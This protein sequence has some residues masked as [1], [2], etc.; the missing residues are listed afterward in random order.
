MATLTIT[1]TKD[2]R[3]A[4][5]N[6]EVNG[7]NITSVVFNTAAISQGSFSSTQ[8]GG[9]SISN[10]VVITADNQTN[11]F[12]VN[13]ATGAS[14]SAAGWTFSNWSAADSV[15]IDG[16][17]DAETITGS[18]QKD[19]IYGGAGADRLD[20]GG[21]DDQFF[22][23]TGD[24]AAGETIIGGSGADLIFMVDRTTFDFRPASVSGVERLQFGNSG[25]GLNIAEVSG[26]QIGSG[27][28]TAVQGAG[29]SFIDRL[30]VY[31]TSINLASVAFTAFDTADTVNLVST[32][33]SASIIGSSVADS[34]T[35]GSGADALAGNDGNDTI[36][37]GDGTNSFEGGGGTDV[38]LGGAGDDSFSY[39]TASILA[40]ANPSAALAGRMT[41]SSSSPMGCS[42]LPSPTSAEWRSWSSR[43]RSLLKRRP[44]SRNPSFPPA[45]SVS[46]SPLRVWHPNSKSAT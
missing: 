10:T 31:G 3:V 5:G 17:S 22:L 26:T 12:Y 32:G 33:A 13:V 38:L 16:N 29:S 34:I 35:G 28:F 36:N 25:A 2:Y 44:G 15:T 6:A 40:R 21:G 9:G 4:P 8:F 19:A 1:A 20:G 30:N 7:Q 42:I 46:S 45:R 11:V 37:G 14:F 18:L 39:F 23:F 41:A 24:L 43:V 27:G